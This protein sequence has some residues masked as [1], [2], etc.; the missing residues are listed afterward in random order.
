MRVQIVYKN[1]YSSIYS[2]LK[3]PEVYQVV[4]WSW[5]RKWNTYSQFSVNLSKNNYKLSIPTKTIILLFF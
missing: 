1:I 5:Y 3:I 4:K 2:I